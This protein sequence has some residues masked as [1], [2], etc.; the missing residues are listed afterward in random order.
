MD[1]LTKTSYILPTDTPVSSA[2]LA[3]HIR[4]AERSGY[5]LTF[6]EHTK[7]MEQWL[8]NLPD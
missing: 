7:E 6:Q 3:N 4:N 2:E 8:N 1:T 5:S